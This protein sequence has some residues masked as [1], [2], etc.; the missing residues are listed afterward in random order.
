MAK[1]L[2]VEDERDTCAMLGKHLALAGHTPVFAH[3]GWEALLLLDDIC[4][5]IAIRQG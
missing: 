1:V 2:V 5:R 3:N 4:E